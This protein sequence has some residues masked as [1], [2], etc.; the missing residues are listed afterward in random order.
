MGYD[1]KQSLLCQ[2]PSAKLHFRY[3]YPHTHSRGP[4]P[5]CSW[6]IFTLKM[7]YELFLKIPV[8][9]NPSLVGDLILCLQ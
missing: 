5:N 2:G 4:F 8:M 6:K 1:D 9:E 3:L 7:E